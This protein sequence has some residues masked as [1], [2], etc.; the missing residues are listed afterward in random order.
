MANV[1]RLRAGFTRLVE[2]CTRAMERVRWGSYYTGLHNNLDLDLHIRE[3]AEWLMRAQDTGSDR[4]ISYGA[5]FGQPFSPSYPETTGYI[6]CTF[7]DLAEF[8]GDQRYVQRA[9]EAADWEIAVQ[10]PCGAVM[11]GLFN[12]NPTPAVFNTGQVLLGWAALHRKTREPRFAE[13]GRRAAVWLLST[14]EDN[15]SWIRGNSRH[16]NP[17]TTVYNVMAA[18]G[19]AEFGYAVGDEQVVAAAIRNAEYALSRQTDN[20]WFADC[21]L[22]DATRPLLHTLGYTMQGLL[23]IGRLTGKEDFIRSAA[24]TADSLLHLMAADGFLPGRLDRHM[25]PAVAWSCLTGIAQ[26][27]AVWWELFR[28]NGDE[29]YREGASRANRYL[30]SRHDVSNSDPVIRGG[31]AGSWPVWGDYGRLMVLNWAA[32]FFID[33]LLAE[34][35]LS[36]AGAGV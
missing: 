34:K 12:T 8:Y 6:I 3:A 29:R 31:V 4:G 17:H 7:L 27:S 33:A 16:A 14:Q 15:G 32:K 13:A 19:L 35:S 22:S 20:G 11:G 10:M 9:L 36:K 18:W 28:G 26:T 1:R 25:R 24:R 5:R 30:M 21:C 23:G 2:P